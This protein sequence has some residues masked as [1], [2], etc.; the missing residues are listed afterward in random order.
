MEILVIAGE[1]ITLGHEAH[2]MKAAAAGGIEGDGWDAYGVQDG[3][4]WLVAA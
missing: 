2:I 4:G 3:I 1:V